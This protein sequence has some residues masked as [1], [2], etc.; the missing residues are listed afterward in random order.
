MIEQGQLL[1]LLGSSY[2]NK[3]VER[4]HG[5]S[6]IAPQN[7]ERPLSKAALSEHWGAQ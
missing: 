6:F 7:V 5:V 3:V 4:L 2:T 1:E